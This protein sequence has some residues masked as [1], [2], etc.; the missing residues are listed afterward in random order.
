MSTGAIIGIVIA[1]VVVVAA[2]AVIAQ[3]VRRARLRRLLGPEYTRLAKELG[4]NRKAEA[5]LAARQRRASDLDIRQLTAEQQ[6]TYT[7]DW[8]AVQ[9]RFVDAPTES[10]QDGRALIERVMRERGYPDGDRDETIVA[11]SVHNARQLDRYRRCLDVD[12]RIESASTEEL[13]ETL[14]QCRELF[15]DLIGSRADTGRRAQLNGE[16]TQL[17]PTGAP[18]SGNSTQER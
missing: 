16:Q 5:E 1:I 12:G 13:R 15:S 18:A 14:L 9:E 17:N 3:E 11:L 2:V 10:L 7:N 6:A 8:T 4:S